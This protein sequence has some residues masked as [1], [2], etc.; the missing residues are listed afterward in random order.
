MKTPG[1]HFLR[2]FMGI[3]FLWIGIAI[4]KNPIAWG[5]L[6]AGWAV[7]LM[8]FSIEHLMIST[9]VLD[10]AI[11]V[12]MLVDFKMRW[13]SLLATLHLLGIIITAGINDIIIRDI[14]LL[15]ATI[16][17][18]VD[19]WPALNKFLTGKK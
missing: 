16:L 11:G 15:G 17:L 5:G 18:T 14:G 4:F 19:D 9:A 7:D 12:L 8:P 13:V 6:M 1:Y 2:V 10:M 3:M